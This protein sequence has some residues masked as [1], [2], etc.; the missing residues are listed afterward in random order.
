MK[1]DPRYEKGLALS[2]TI[3]LRAAR[4]SLGQLDFHTQRRTPRTHP[5]LQRPRPLMTRC[6][7]ECR[8]LA[9]GRMVLDPDGA[10]GSEGR[11]PW[12]L[13]AILSVPGSPLILS[14]CRSVCRQIRGSSPGLVLVFRSHRRELSCPCGDMSSTRGLPGSTH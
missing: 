14:V 1:T 6:S 7:L 9:P 4:G 12:G 5:K 13:P 8:H 2:G 11:E 10:L 3:E